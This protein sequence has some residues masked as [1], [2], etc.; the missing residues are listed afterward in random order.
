VTEVDRVA[1]WQEHL[2]VEL[3]GAQVVFTTRRGGFSSGPFESFNLGRLTDDRPEAVVGNRRRLQD[4]VGRRLAMVRQVHGATVHLADGAWPD[5]TGQ[6]L[7]PLREG[8]GVLT[9]SGELAPMVLVADCLPVALAGAGAVA[10][11]HAGWR[12][13]ASGVLDEGVRML[14]DLVPEAEIAAAIGPGI[15]LCC[16]E[17]GEEVHRAFE[18]YGEEI[19][20]GQNLDLRA[21]ARI[22]LEQAGVEI[23]HD[24]DLCTSCSPELFFSHRR[25]RGVTG[26]QAGVIWLS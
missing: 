20:Q 13:L 12:G 26:R 7:T 23:R 14:R 10:M 9:T 1:S 19:R 3:T 5:A 16:Y 11:V 18:A 17:V 24:V 8:D 6:E 25:D 21:I 4:R 15:G 22:Q 2:T